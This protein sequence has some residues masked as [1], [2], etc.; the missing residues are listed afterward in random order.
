M[1]EHIPA[2]E[3]DQENL[4]GEAIKDLL[5][6][7]DV[8]ANCWHE[9]YEDAVVLHPFEP[10]SAEGLADVRA[11]LDTLAAELGGPVTVRQLREIGE[12]DGPHEVARWHYG[13]YALTFPRGT[14]G[15]AVR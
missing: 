10:M 7:L 6:D 3:R 4:R 11:S 12:A 1:N 8:I 15:P 14:Y 13:F 5:Y 9:R 2:R